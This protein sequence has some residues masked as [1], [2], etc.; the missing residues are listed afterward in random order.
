M[1][2]LLLNPQA[3]SQ[4]RHEKKGRNEDLQTASGAEALSFEKVKIDLGEIREDGE[5]A[6]CTF[7]WCNTGDSAVMVLMVSTT[8]GC[9]VPHFSRTPVAAGEEGE[10]RLTYYPKGHP[11]KISHKAMVYI[12][13]SS[14]RPAAVLAV[15]AD[16]I[17]AELPYWNYPE[18]I[19]SLRL[20]HKIF[21]FDRLDVRQVRRIECLNVGDDTLSLRSMEGCLPPGFEFRT[22][23]EAIPHAGTGD[24]VL[25]FDPGKCPD[26]ETLSS[27]ELYIEG[28]GVKT[29]STSVKVMLPSR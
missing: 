16:V 10:I 1:L 14:A 3:H 29:D 8:C 20:K 15:T 11:G 6:S 17:P 4:S 24:L 5:P 13:S 26:P 22:E 18:E 21:R 9:L 23:P 28:L 27:F 25:S 7:R 2:I 19:G 12:N